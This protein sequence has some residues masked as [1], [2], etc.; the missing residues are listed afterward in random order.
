VADAG[1]PRGAGRPNRGGADGASGG[2][3]GGAGVGTSEELVRE[4]IACAERTLAAPRARIELDRRID[5][6]WPERPR[7]ARRRGGVLRPVGELAKRAGKAAWNHWF[8]GERFGHLTGEGIIEPPARRY[9]I[10]F[11][12]YAEVYEQGARWGGGSGQP[13]GT[14]D[15][16]PAERQADVWWLL[17]VLRGVVDARVEAED[18]LHGV[19]CRRVATRVDLSRASELSPG[20]LYVPKVRRYEELEALPVTTWIDGQHI[21]RVRFTDGDEAST[22]LTLDL[23]EFDP[24]TGR[25]DWRRFPDFRSAANR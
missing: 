15:P 11:G 21:R 13:I 22:T 7:I 3:G 20:G 4:V 12:S 24:E 9:M 8:D 6:A 5:F 23:V 2:G 25:I 17:D 14:R 19:P 10:D 1:A 18:S 16:W